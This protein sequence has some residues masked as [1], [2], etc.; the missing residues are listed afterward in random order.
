MRSDSRFEVSGID[1]AM[2][3]RDPWLKRRV[4]RAE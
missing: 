1:D 2:Q 4:A 3:N